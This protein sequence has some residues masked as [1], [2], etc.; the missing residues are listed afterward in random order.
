MSEKQTNQKKKL[1][2]AFLNEA[3]K[4]FNELLV[5]S[6]LEGLDFGEV[7]LRFLEL[8]SQV[9]RDS[10]AEKPELFVEK[11]EDLL[12]VWMAGIFEERILRILCGKLGIEYSV[13][14]ALTFSKAVKKALKEYLKTCQNG[15]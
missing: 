13:I 1:G 9:K 15:T 8:K 7:V 6:I 12:G 3:K 4:K 11:L 5:E 10:I 14:D 2:D